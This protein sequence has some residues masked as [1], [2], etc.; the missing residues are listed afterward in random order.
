MMLRRLLTRALGVPTVRAIRGATVATAD[1][2]DAIAEAITELLAAMRHENMLRHDEVISA[3]FTVTPD[4]VSAFP[5]E[6][7][8]LA[9]WQHV[10]LICT[11]EIAVPDGLP[12]CMRVMLHVERRWNGTPARHVYLREAVRL[13]PDLTRET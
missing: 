9:G 7:A 4:L 5:A 1:Q 10:P 12:R 11:T 2:P 13:R 8:R 3:I 6:A